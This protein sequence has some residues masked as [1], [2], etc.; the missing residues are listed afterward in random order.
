M[1]ESG[2]VTGTPKFAPSMSNCTEAMPNASDA[3]ALTASVPLGTGSEGI[4]H[5]LW[6]GWRVQVVERLPLRAFAFGGDAVT[7]CPLTRDYDFLLRSVDDMRPG[8][9]KQG[10]AIGMGIQNAAARKLGGAD[11]TTTVLSMA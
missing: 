3:L 8:E 6:Q 5:E 10:T 9:M 11:F 7:K 1:P 4:V 2:V